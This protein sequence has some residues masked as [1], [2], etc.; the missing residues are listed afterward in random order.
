ME[1]VWYYARRYVGTHFHLLPPLGTLALGPL[2]TVFVQTRFSV[3][4]IDGLSRYGQTQPGLSSVGY[5][6]V[7][8][9]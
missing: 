3:W 5:G 9:L 7:F 2:P 8:C 1:L 6:F 4:A